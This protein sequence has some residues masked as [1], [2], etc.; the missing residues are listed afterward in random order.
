MIVALSLSGAIPAA[1]ASP[2]SFSVTDLGL[3]TATFGTD[4]S[5]QTV[6]VASSGR[7]AYAFDPANAVVQDGSLVPVVSPVPSNL[8]ILEPVQNPS[9][10]PPTNFSVNSQ[11]MMNA[12]G[13]GVAI[14]SLGVWGHDSTDQVFFSHQN[15]DGTWGTPVRMW[16]GIPQYM[17]NGPKVDARIFGI[18]NT[19]LVLGTMGFGPYDHNTA[20]YDINNRSLLDL[21]QYLYNVSARGAAGFVSMGERGDDGWWS[22]L[23]I[24]ID[25]DGRILVQA[26]AGVVGQSHTL[27]L[28]PDGATSDPIAV[29]EP[30]SVALA[31]V[32]ASWFAFRARSGKSG[33]RRG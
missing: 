27:L 16:T 19:N 22:A 31:V 20:V 29:P 33:L 24:G 15:G 1:N 11:F 9:G 28:T 6:V 10:V 5:G 2:L 30:S 17:I 26:T 7:T 12:N 8:P 21:T 13:F 32:A 4:A 3:G 18:S 14:D 23:P 25:R